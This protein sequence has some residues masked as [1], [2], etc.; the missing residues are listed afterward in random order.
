MTENLPTV[1]T[2][3]DN[4]TNDP[5]CLP[6]LSDW[7]DIKDGPVVLLA[8]RREPRYDDGPTWPGP[9]SAA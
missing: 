3:H 4:I 7:V 1:W 8:G 5:E 9:A 6:G 2:I